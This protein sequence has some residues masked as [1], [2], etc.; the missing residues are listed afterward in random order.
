MLKKISYDTY[1]VQDNAVT[2]GIG[3]IFLKNTNEIDFSFSTGLRKTENKIYPDEK[4]VNI[5]FA[6]SSGDI[7]FKKIRRK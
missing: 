2:F 6:I 5:N 1:T 7:W 4:Y 3:F